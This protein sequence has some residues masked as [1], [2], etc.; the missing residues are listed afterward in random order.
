[1][2]CIEHLLRLDACLIDNVNIILSSYLLFEIVHA[3]ILY[4]KFL[5]M[6]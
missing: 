6:P 4:V 3:L 2:Q 5:F 1:M